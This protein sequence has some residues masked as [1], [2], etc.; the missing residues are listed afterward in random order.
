DKCPCKIVGS[1]YRNLRNQLVQF[2]DFSFPATPVFPSFTK[3]GGLL[4][5]VLKVLNIQVKGHN[6]E[7]CGSSP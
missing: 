7:D 5:Q 6:M 1:F 4:D 2:I 3:Q